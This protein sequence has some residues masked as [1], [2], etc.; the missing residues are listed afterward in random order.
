M[1]LT[2]PDY[3]QGAFALSWRAGGGGRDKKGAF[4]P[5]VSCYSPLWD[6]ESMSYHRSVL[7]TQKPL[8]ISSPKAR[9]HLQVRFMILGP[10]REKF[11]PFSASWYLAPSGDEVVHMDDGT[12][13]DEMAT[14]FS[15]Y[16][17]PME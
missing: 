4:D 10:Y 14:P 5:L 8:T 11:A 6:S 12:K 9:C 7:Q 1:P 17:L 13:H 2:D 15:Q 16:H 3:G